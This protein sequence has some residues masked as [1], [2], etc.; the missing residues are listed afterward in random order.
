ML[1]SFSTRAFVSLAVAS[2]AL[3]AA[4]GAAFAGEARVV[5]KLPSFR[6]SAGEANR[7]TV[8]RTG[9]RTFTIEDLGAPVTPG[10]GCTA[11]SANKARCIAP[12]RRSV[13]PGPVN[14]GDGDDAATTRGADVPVLLDGGAGSDRLSAGSGS[15]PVLAGGPDDDILTGGEGD[16]LIFGEA[17]FD[18]GAAGNDQIDGRG[19]DDRIEGGLGTDVIVGGAGTDTVIYQEFAIASGQALRT[20][21]VTVTLDAMAN[22]GAPGENDSVAGDVENVIGATGAD[23][24]VGNEADNSLRLGFAGVGDPTGGSVQGAGGDDAVFGGEGPDTVDGGAGD[25]IVVDGDVGGAASTLSGGPGND[26][27]HAAD[28]AEEQSNTSELELNPT[29]DAISC[30]AGRDQAYLDTADP[31]PADCE[32]FTIRTP[33]LAT[34]RGTEGKDVIVGVQ[35][36]GG[37]D[38]IIA[39]AGND[40]ASGLGGNDRID[41]GAGRDTLS[42]GDGNDVIRARDGERDKIS[43]GTGRD[44]VSADRSDRVSS[45]C[46]RVSRSPT[47]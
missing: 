39:R 3:A 28:V 9:A 15:A 40:R 43:C 17:G 1:G 45:D 34:T 46:E 27:L 41:G 26:L 12:G 31:R 36:E 29:A 47:R 2:A 37:D 30:G 8:A 21:P 18:Q 6:A 44:V 33:T 13:I 11:V 19:G 32:I 5:N 24:L 20:T 14:L 38:R 16:D 35:G 23:Q 22:D 7:V 25:D 4:P 42:G 10:A